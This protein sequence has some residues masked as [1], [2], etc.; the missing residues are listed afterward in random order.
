MITPADPATPASTRAHGPPGPH[1]GDVDEDEAAVGQIREN[2]V[3]TAIGGAIRLR[4][5]V[6][7]YLASHVHLLYSL[8]RSAHKA[9]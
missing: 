7:G 4:G 9:R 1:K 3:E 2:F 5:R 8:T 6:N